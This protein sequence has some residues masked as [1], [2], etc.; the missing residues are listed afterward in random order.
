MVVIMANNAKWNLQGNIWAS[1]GFMTIKDSKW[2][3]FPSTYPYRL[4]VEQIVSNAVTKREIVE[5]TNRTWDTFSITRAVE[6]CPLNDNATTT[7]QTWQAFTDDALVQLRT[8]GEIIESINSKLDKV[9]YYKWDLV[10]W[11]TSWGSNNYA[12]TVDSS[13]TSYND[14]QVFRFLTDFENTG[15]V[16][17]NVNSIWA[18]PI[19]KNND[20][21]L[22]SWDLE[23][24]QI[25]EVVYNGVTTTFAMTSQIATLPTVDINSL[26]ETV[27]V[28]RANDEVII[29]DASELANRKV[30]I[31]NIADS[32]SESNEW[33]VFK[34]SDVEVLAWTEDTKYTTPKQV[35]DGSLN[36]VY[37]STIDWDNVYE[38]IP[39]WLQTLTNN[40]TVTWGK[41]YEQVN[42]TWANP[43]IS[44][45]LHWKPWVSI[46]VQINTLE[47][48]EVEFNATKDP[49]SSLFKVWFVTTTVPLYTNA[50]TVKKVLMEYDT[51]TSVRLRTADGTTEEVSSAFSISSNQTNR[52]K[53]T[54]DRILWEVRF[55][56][57]NSLV[58]TNSTNIPTGSDTLEFW[59]WAENAT[60]I[61][62]DTFKVRYKFT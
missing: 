29:Y 30:K 7:T 46:T 49:A 27:A 19:K 48:I 23:A 17:F 5:V 43:Y 38:I 51:T 28:D 61:T 52:Y 13:V 9:D 31:T 2:E 55:Y 18:V 57:N 20:L 54:F 21:D 42:A 26:T 60:D 56:L 59:V 1:T 34:S 53:I 44:T 33:L 41:P 35:K 12:I 16:T 40:M 22:Q 4:T 45:D 37:G 8:T 10:Y 6:A 50:S 58:A 3:L 47:Y 24:N 36:S 62:V 25:V 15:A 11:A 32:A 14:W 39:S